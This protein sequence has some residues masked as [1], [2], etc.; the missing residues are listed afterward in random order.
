MKKE[1]VDA[2]HRKVQAGQEKMYKVSCIKA[3][4]EL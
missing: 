1:K 2:I 4:Y 3:L